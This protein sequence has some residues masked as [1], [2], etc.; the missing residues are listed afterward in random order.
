M[1]LRK[2]KSISVDCRGFSRTT[3]EKIYLKNK[4]RWQREEFSGREMK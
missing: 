3:G 4:T 2:K 1:L